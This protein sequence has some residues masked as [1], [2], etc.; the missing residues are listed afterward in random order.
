M[1]TEENKA[2]LR[3]WLEPPGGWENL[4]RRIYEAEDAKTKMEEYYYRTAR[5]EFFAPNFIRHHTRGD[6]NLDS[7]IQHDS[8]LWAAI[9]DLNISIKEIIGEG[10]WIMARLTTRGTH[11]GTFQGIPATGKKIE[12]GGMI[13]CRFVE[14]KIAE[15]WAYH[16]ELSL[17]Q[18]L[19]AIPSR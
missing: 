14:G 12:I 16:D 6:M 11:K 8:A 7:Y 17:M 4:N 10:D 18:Q 2:L 19:G 15:V 5:S 3:R 9:P 1:S 13:A